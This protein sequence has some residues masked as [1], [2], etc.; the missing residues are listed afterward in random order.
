MMKKCAVGDLGTFDLEFSKD[1]SAVAV[2]TVSKGYPGSY[3]K[4]F[5]ITGTAQMLVHMARDTPLFI[6]KI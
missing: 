4:G 5:P 3:A 1:Q 2:M 6:K